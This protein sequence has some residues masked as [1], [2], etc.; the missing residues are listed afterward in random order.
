MEYEDAR[1][2]TAL[3]QEE[4]RKQAIRLSKQGWQYKKIS[5]V[6]GV[7][8]ETVGKWVRLYRSQG[9]KGIQARK[10]GPSFGNRC[11]LNTDQ[12]QVI[13]KMIIDQ[14][15]EQLKMP[16]ALCLMDT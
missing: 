7:H 16:Y 5:K 11:L 13:K 12:E 14:V 8:F 9:M 4:K 1:K 15:P 10:Q 6:V 2:I 3:A